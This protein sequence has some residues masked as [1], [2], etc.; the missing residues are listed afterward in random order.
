MLRKLIGI[1]FLVVFLLS[2]P[3]FSLAHPFEVGEK[4]VY[5]IKL[6]GIPAG[7]QVLKVE[8]I[9]ESENG[10]LYFLSSK[11][12]TSGIIS[13]FYRME[14][15]IESYVDVE[16]LH[17]RLV[18]MRVQEN[19]NVKEMEI[20]IKKEDK[21]KA[22]FYDRKTNK[23]WAEQLSSFPLDMLSL[24]YWGR[25]QELK[26][27]QKYDVLLLDA[28]GNFNNVQC[29]I[30]GVE[31]AYTYLGV[32]PAFVC[33]QT[34]IKNGVRVWF[35]QDERR[36]PLYLQLNTPYGLLTAILQKVD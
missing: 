1:L 9:I 33:K 18:K 22:F 23:K 14:N 28:A 2:F 25:S 10:P 8:G 19:S 24:I 34:G 21:I 16:T 6:I 11:L 31:K 26:I 12:T 20:V 4:L 13:L 36:L 29:E 27:G 32:F 15:E 5:T 3:S 35:S 17:S 30:S 7:T